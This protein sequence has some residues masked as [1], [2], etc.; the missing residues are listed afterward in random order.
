MSI[1]GVYTGY[2]PGILISMS[3]SIGVQSGFYLYLI[4]RADIYN[5][6]SNYTGY[7]SRK[8][9]VSKIRLLHKLTRSLYISLVA[10]PAVWHG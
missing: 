3:D 6:P 5:V 4:C 9:E 2:E 10:G 1:P 7:T 8:F